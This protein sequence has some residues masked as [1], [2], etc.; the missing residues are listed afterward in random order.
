MVVQWFT[1]S[2]CSVSRCWNLLTAS[3]EKTNSV[4]TKEVIFA[5]LRRDDGFRGCPRKMLWWRDLQT[6]TSF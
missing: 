3:M 4:A 6:M 1:M 2:Q 5:S